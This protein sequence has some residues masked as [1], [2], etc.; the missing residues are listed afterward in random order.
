M[1]VSFRFQDI[2]SNIII[3]VQKKEKIK[4]ISIEYIVDTVILKEY[5]SIQKPF[6]S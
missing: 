6:S 5:H 2:L 1:Q 3:E 4:G